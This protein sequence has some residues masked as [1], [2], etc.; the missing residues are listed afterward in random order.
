MIHAVMKKHLYNSGFGKV[1]WFIDRFGAREVFLKPMRIAFAPLIIP[2]LPRRIFEFEGRKLEYF[3]HRYNMTWASERCIEVPIARD[4]L[5]R[6]AGRA[7]L[8]VGNV[9]SHYGPVT[10]EVLD[11]FEKGPCVIN[12][13]IVTFAPGKAYDLILSVSTFEHIGFDDEAAEPS[14]EKIRAALGACRRLLKPDG[15]LVITVPIGYNPHL[16]ALIRTGGLG[17]RREIF[18]KRT[19][20]L[21][22]RSVDRNEALACRFKSPFP[23]ANAILLAEF[24]AEE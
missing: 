4:Y 20:Q 16:D 22:W 23:Y 5:S 2:R 19:G 10:H 7:A 6:F 8:E 1:K 15:L 18:F 11:K 14:G 21:E 12:E 24:Q 13:D 3:Y 17:A 9:L